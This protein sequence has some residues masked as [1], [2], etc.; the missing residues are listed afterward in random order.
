MIDVFLYRNVLI[1]KS[2]DYEIYRELWV[3]V[4]W[5]SDFQEDPLGT[6]RLKRLF[7]LCKP[8]R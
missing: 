8:E 4:T 5:Q 1:R 2:T 7:V 6:V 3:G